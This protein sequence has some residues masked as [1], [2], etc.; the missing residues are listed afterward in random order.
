M[1]DIAIQYMQYCPT[2][3]GRREYNFAQA[4]NHLW[5]LDI[6]VYINNI[7]IYVLLY[8]ISAMH[9]DYKI[10]HVVDNSTTWI[11]CRPRTLASIGWKRAGNCAEANQEH[12]QSQE[13]DLVC[14]WRDGSIHGDSGPHLQWT[15]ERG[16][17]GGKRPRIR[18]I[19][20]RGSIKSKRYI[21]FI[22]KLCVKVYKQSLTIK[23]FFH[24]LKESFI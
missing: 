23:M 2:M 3:F 17:R 22:I 8:W 20:Q 16:V 18:E 14:G 9:K 4:F 24:H 1:H 12:Q 7:I 21:S 13:C 11:Y 5:N 10:L 6:S 19:P 15:A